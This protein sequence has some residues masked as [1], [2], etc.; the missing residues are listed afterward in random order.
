MK[1]RLGLEVGRSADQRNR[2]RP[3]FVSPCV[4]K[5]R[6]MP[7][8]MVQLMAAVLLATVALRYHY[9]ADVIAGAA[10]APVGLWLTCAL[11]RACA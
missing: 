10:L 5:V 11:R 2:W 4:N 7:K 6:R 9:V 3:P 1:V 8:R